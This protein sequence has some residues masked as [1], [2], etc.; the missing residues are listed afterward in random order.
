MLDIIRDNIYLPLLQANYPHL[1]RKYKNRLEDAIIDIHIGKPDAIRNMT[2]LIAEIKADKET[3]T[4]QELY[5]PKVRITLID[6][7]KRV[8]A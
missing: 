6:L 1:N 4:W 2:K 5:A 3:K 7:V 8:L